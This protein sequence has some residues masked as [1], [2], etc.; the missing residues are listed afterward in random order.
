[1]NYKTMDRQRRYLLI[2]AAAGV[3]S[4]FLPWVKMDVGGFLQG[5]GVG[6][7]INGFRGIGILVFIAYVVCGLLAFAGDQQRPLDK[8][9][10]LTVLGAAAVS[11]IGIFGFFISAGND[12]SMGMGL[13]D[14]KPGIGSWVAFF[15]T[16]GILI[17]ALAFKSKSHSLKDSFDSMKKNI[18]T[19]MQHSNTTGSNDRI[20]EL[21]KLIALKEQGK[22]TEE[23][24]Q[25]MKSKLL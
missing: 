17:S 10:W 19:M 14:I 2:A 3:I 21:E 20:S 6:H 16:L 18:S 4:V 7:S 5:L 12:A 25:Q 8:T 22:I 15:A 23:E 13:V 11:I 9:P 1:M 24:Y